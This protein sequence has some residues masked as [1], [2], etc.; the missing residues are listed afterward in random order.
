MSFK[1][2]WRDAKTVPEV[3]SDLEQRFGLKRVV[4]VGDRGSSH[5]VDLV[6]E[7]G[8]GYIVGPIE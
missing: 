7:H 4:F 1:A 6:R 5:N 2:N 8:H 3:L